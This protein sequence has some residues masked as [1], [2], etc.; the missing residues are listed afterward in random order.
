[1]IL[2]GWEAVESKAPEQAPKRREHTTMRERQRNWGAADAAVM[3]EGSQ[4]HRDG[5]PVEL[6]LT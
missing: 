1:M 2:D 4:D 5:E 6:Q 3:P